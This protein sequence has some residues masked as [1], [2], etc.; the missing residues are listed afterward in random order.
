M[1][2]LSK[3]IKNMKQNH[4]NTRNASYKSFLVK[5]FLSAA[6][7]ATGILGSALQSS[8]AIQS[9]GMQLQR[10]DGDQL[11]L[12]IFY[13]DAA[14]FTIN[15]VGLYSALRPV[16][17]TNLPGPFK[18]TTTANPVPGYD[19]N[20]FTGYAITGVT[21]K[22]FDAVQNE[23]YEVKSICPSSAINTPLPGPP[24]HYS[25]TFPGCSLP[26]FGSPADSTNGLFSEGSY[27]EGISTFIAHTLSDNLFKPD[28]VDQ[29]V[30]KG[31]FS[32]GGIVFN[33]PYL[34]EAGGY[35][36]QLFSEAANDNELAGCGSGTCLPVTFRVPGPL[37]LLGVGAAFAYSRTL[38]NRIKRGQASGI[39]N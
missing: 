17:A 20:G 9:K 23:W 36:Y 15:S 2:Y 38:R 8:A 35:N 11:D 32:S 6:A 10:P 14:Q 7:V 16:V 30:L 5:N 22:Y 13:D 21:G 3:G 31:I 33:T 27:T 1:S 29:K 25:T 4:G 18:D 39:L 37:P 28:L 19:P 24:V 12:T 26:T 34:N